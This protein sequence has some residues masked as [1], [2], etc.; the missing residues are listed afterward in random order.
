MQTFYFWCGSRLVG[1]AKG[2]TEQE[3]RQKV[4]EEIKMGINWNIKSEVENAVAK[5]Y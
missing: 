5:V 4:L 3:A 2:E 1:V